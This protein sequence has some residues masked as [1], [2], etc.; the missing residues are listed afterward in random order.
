MDNDQIQ[1]ILNDAITCMQDA[2]QR[3][4]SGKAG[5]RVL[6]AMI[7]VLAQQ[8]LTQ[9]QQ[10][11]IETLLDMHEKCISLDGKTKTVSD[12]IERQLS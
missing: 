7:A 8:L 6:H 10:Q 2:Q 5:T 3:V 4:Y 1:K 9:E 11:Q 12:S